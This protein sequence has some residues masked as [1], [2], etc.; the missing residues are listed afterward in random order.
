MTILASLRQ[1]LISLLPILLIVGVIMGLVMFAL[2]NIVKPWQSQAQL[3]V[4][5]TAVFATVEA[6]QLQ[7]EID[8]NP[9]TILRRLDKAQAELVQNASIFMTSEQA[10]NILQTLY[11]YADLS[12][13][14][15]GTLQ[16]QNTPNQD[17]PSQG[18]NKPQQTTAIPP[19]YT[20]QALRLQVS[21]SL[22]KL[23]SFI[24]RIREANVPG[25]S[26]NNLS[27]KESLE[28][29]LL[30]MDILIYTS[31]L[32]SGES[33]AHL[34]P[35]II[36]TR[37]TFD[38]VPTS[39]PPV[40]ESVVV[41]TPD[42]STATPEPEPA[43]LLVYSDSFDNSNLDRWRLGAG[44]SLVSSGESQMLQVFDSSADVT[45][46]HS[47]LQDV[48]VNVQVFLD[49]GSLRLS[50]RQSAAGR[51]T[52]LLQPT[53]QVALYRG[54]ALIKTVTVPIS[55]V[56]R[57]REVHLSV[58]GGVIRASIDGHNLIEAIDTAE[59]PPG[60]LSFALVGG[61]TM[62]VDDVQIWALPEL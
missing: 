59:L 40:A 61:G 35:V 50:L 60:A 17:N 44:W 1:R 39:T 41:L 4:E 42:V 33:Y 32:S 52:L 16:T 43:L 58:L 22:I 53:G 48:A 25:V 34:E 2:T 46:I 49:H 19:A 7:I 38:V 21:G 3:S 51:Y 12:E 8:S 14:E 36:P 27:L 28:G 18:K 54:D 47:T 15:I 9:E 37:T 13:V 56:S 5:V 31:H 24:T 30:T 23:M 45:Y 55:G 26:I 62:K 20:V 29:S 6:Q 10:D 57:W 11:S